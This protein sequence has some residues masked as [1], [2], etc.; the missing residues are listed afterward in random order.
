M[1]LSV[2]WQNLVYV[3][4]KKSQQQIKDSDYVRFIIELSSLVKLIEMNLISVPNEFIKL[5]HHQRVQSHW[6]D[7]VEE[8]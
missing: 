1:N 2:K 3:I 7:T 8:L 5:K 4:K 6:Q